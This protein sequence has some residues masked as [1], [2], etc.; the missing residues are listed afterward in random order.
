MTGC[1]LKSSK[2]SCNPREKSSKK[3]VKS[4]VMREW[5]A[6]NQ[7]RRDTHLICL[8][9]ASIFL[10]PY[11]GQLA[12]ATII[13]EVLTFIYWVCLEHSC[14]HDRIDLVLPLYSI[15][16]R[17][18]RGCKVSQLASRLPCAFYVYHLCF[19]WNSRLARR[20]LCKLHMVLVPLAFFLPCC[21]R[22]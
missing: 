21:L 13:I 8:W 9:A 18:P 1:D 6:R 3:H 5:K 11:M 16:S 12:L 22:Y 15:L 7:D 17:P 2:F 19:A 20:A 4:K 14:S 10:V